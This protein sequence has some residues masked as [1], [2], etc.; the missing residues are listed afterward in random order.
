MKST[1]TKMGD[2]VTSYDNLL[3]KTTY[4]HVRANTASASGHTFPSCWLPNGGLAA[5]TIQAM[6]LFITTKQ[7]LAIY[8]VNEHRDYHSD[9]VVFCTA[10]SISSVVSF[11]K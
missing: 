9:A 6:R 11:D 2:A 8:S 3:F 4:I 10:I 7:A 1:F 5:R